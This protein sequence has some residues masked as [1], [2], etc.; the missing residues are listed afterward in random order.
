MD[1]GKETKPRTKYTS[2]LLR[3]VVGLAQRGHVGDF[4]PPMLRKQLWPVLLHQG[5]KFVAHQIGVNVPADAPVV[6]EPDFPEVY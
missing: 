5:P 1:L 4:S 3:R 2:G 6:V